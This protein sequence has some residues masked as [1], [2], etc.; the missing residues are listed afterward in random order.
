MGRFITEVGS[1]PDLVLTSPA[2]RART[3]AELANESGGW[4]ASIEV[5]ESFYGGGPLDVIN[6]VRTAAPS[7]E[8]V[9]VAGHEPTWSDLV[10]L[11]TGGRVGMPTAAVAAVAVVGSG[12]SKL[13][14]GLC[15]LDWLIRPRMLKRLI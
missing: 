9:L 10:E 3:T 13:G 14:P 2:V 1:P 5:V 4:D 11:L 7:A 15:E 8:C 12:W 6:G